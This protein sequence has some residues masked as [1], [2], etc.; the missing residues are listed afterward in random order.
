[1]KKEEGWLRSAQ[2][3]LREIVFQ[4]D[5]AAIMEPL[6]VPVIAYDKSPHQVVHDLVIP[7]IR[8]L[9]QQRDDLNDMVNRTQALLV[10]EQ[11]ANASVASPEGGT[12]T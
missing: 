6:G 7:A 11:E 2:A 9:V 4:D 8:R 3:R 10:Q 1:V 5:I 12:E